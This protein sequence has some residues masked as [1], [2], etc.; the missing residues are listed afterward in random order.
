MPTSS[1][2]RRDPSPP[3]SPRPEPLS[4]FDRFFILFASVT[5]SMLAYKSIRP[6]LFQKGLSFTILA[7]GSAYAL[8]INCKCCKKTIESIFNGFDGCSLGGAGSGRTFHYPSYPQERRGWG[9][10]EWGGTSSSHNGHFER[11]E[12][13]YCG[14]G[15]G[16]G[17]GFPPSSPSTHTAVPDGQRKRFEDRD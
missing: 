5:G 16:G 9:F 12:D 4:S 2:A 14:G 11:R 8:G 1:P 13:E 10:E 7:G 6:G 3:R 17:G 15:G